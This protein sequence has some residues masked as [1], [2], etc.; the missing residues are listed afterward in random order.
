MAGRD[1]IRVIAAV[2]VRDGRWL[3]AKR[4][5]HKRHGGLWEFPGGKLEAGETDA[6]AAARELD[7]ELNV[8][9]VG[10]GPV[11]FEQSDPGSPFLIVYRQVEAEGQPAAVEHDE[12]R[13]VTA[14][15]AA[16]LNLAPADAAFVAHMTAKMS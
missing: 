5:A 9:V 15:E 8:T 7:E 2:V 1:S 10:V 14:D 12:L 4:P 3:L 11:L 13:W 16:R 6:Q